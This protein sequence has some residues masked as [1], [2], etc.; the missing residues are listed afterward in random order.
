[1]AHLVIA[2]IIL[3]TPDGIGVHSHIVTTDCASELQAIVAEFP[4]AVPVFADCMSIDVEVDQ[5]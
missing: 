1:M 5:A 3:L 2:L 4:G